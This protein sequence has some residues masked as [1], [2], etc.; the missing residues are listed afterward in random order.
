MTQTTP[1]PRPIRPNQRRSRRQPPK[2]STKARVT[3]NALGLGP[4]IAVTVL[5]LSETGVRLLL[6]EELADGQEF[7][8]TLEGAAVGR[9]VKAV[10]QVVW[11][12][13]TADGQFCIGASFPKPITYASLQALSRQ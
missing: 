1:L 8:V 7:E 9:P 6:K 4:N 3:R 13:A 11:C 12:V 5:D 10:A 2:G